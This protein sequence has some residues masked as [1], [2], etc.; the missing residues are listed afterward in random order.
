MANWVLNKVS[1]LGEEENLK[2]INEVMKGLQSEELKTGFGQVPKF[3]ES[4]QDKKKTTY[5]F[6]IG[7]IDDNEYEFETKWAA[8]ITELVRIAEHYNI[9]IIH[10]YD[11]EEEYL[12]GEAYIADGKVEIIELEDEVFERIIYNEENDNYCY[13]GKIFD[14]QYEIYEDE[15]AQREKEIYT[16][17][18]FIK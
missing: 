14:S 11:C 6:N 10:R 9:K 16:Y 18:D 2:R 5:F 4:I 8:P 13:E 15:L 3:I 12:Y 1:F 7:Y 17:E